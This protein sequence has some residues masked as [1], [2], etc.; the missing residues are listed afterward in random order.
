[1]EP[2]EIEIRAQSGGTVLMTR[3][4]VG[5]W[6]KQE[7]FAPFVTHGRR[8]VV[9]AL[10]PGFGPMGGALPDRHAQEAGGGS[11][12]GGMTVRI[13]SEAING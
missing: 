10:L 11:R 1:M 7:P 5:Q 4:D 2:A 12:E 6:L 8:T 3:D 13:E 9:R